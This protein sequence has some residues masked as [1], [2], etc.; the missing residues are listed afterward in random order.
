MQ[1]ITNPITAPMI[2][3]TFM[4]CVKIKYEAAPEIKKHMNADDNALSSNF[5]IIFF[6]ISCHIRQPCN[7]LSVTNLQQD[8]CGKTYPYPHNIPIQHSVYLIMYRVR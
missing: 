5:I 8:V 4:L 1:Y 6:V 2:A 3:D 7:Q